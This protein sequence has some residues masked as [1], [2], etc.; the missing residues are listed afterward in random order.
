MLRGLLNAA[1]SL[2]DQTDPQIVGLRLKPS[3]SQGSRR[4]PAW[5]PTHGT[6][7]NTL[8]DWTAS[9]NGP[10]MVEAA[11]LECELDHTVGPARI[12]FFTA[13]VTDNQ[14]EWSRTAIA[15]RPPHRSRR[16]LIVPPAARFKRSNYFSPLMFALQ[17][18]I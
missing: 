12:I 14:S 4:Q 5:N 18:V 6:S 2:G 9:T 17:D 13:N 8:T 10:T 15:D 3:A 7:T 16:A 1:Q 11:V